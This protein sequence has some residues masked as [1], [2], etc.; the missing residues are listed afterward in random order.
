MIDITP[1]AITAVASKRLLAKLITE[2]SISGTGSPEI[3]SQR[4]SA[5]TK[6]LATAERLKTKDKLALIA[7]ASVIAD[8]VD[9]GWLVR[10][11]R[12]ERILA[13]RPSDD[14]D[15]TRLHKRRRYEVARDAQLRQTAARAFIEGME[16]GALTSTGRHSIFSLMRDGRHLQREIA[17]ALAGTSNRALADVI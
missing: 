16:R 8:L 5:R 6:F 11:N 7:S 14:E 13:Q 1:T 17:D 2:L 9:Q 15:E 3:K 10:T 12:K 4:L